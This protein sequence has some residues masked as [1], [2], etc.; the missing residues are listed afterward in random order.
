M[1]AEPKLNYITLALTNNVVPTQIT[2][3]SI[4][5]SVKNFVHTEEVTANRI[6]ITNAGMYTLQRPRLRLFKPVKKL[7][8]TITQIQLQ[9]PRQKGLQ[10]QLVNWHFTHDQM[11]CDQ[12]L[13]HNMRDKFH[14]CNAIMINCNVTQTLQ[15]LYVVC[16]V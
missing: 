15:T 4:E 13:Q 10:L 12:N 8:F 14:A 2:I 11:H 1:A 9:C 7:K 16:Y 6:I 3:H 5:Q